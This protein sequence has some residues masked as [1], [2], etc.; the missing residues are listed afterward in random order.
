MSFVNK[1]GDP[2][3]IDFEKDEQMLVKKY[4]PSDGTVLELG[5][6]Y[7]T[8][9]CVITSV[10]DDPTRHVAVEPDSTVIEALEKNRA[11]NDGKFHIFNGVV[12]NKNFTLKRP[13]CCEYSTCT[14][15]SDIP[16][17]YSLSLDKLQDKYNLKFDCLVA[18][19]EGFFPKFI[20]ENTW[21]L[22]QVRVIIYEKDG[23]PWDGP[24]YDAL[25]QM[26]TEKGF[27][28]MESIPH[29]KYANNPH[30]HSAWVKTSG[31]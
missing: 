20:D 17:L 22:D 25:D 13:E 21:I 12:S 15:E 4:I 24:R 27:V 31:K 11:R 10:L 30:F 9:S 23:I 7:G 29:P 5:A 28:R 26:L 18:D 2:V 14:E 1:N 3:D 19:C 6:R 8:V 16:S